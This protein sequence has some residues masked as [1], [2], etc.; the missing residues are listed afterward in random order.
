MKLPQL[1]QRLLFSKKAQTAEQD[2]EKELRSQ[3]A[4]LERQGVAFNESLG[5]L[6]AAL[7][8]SNGAELTEQQRAQDLAQLRLQTQTSPQAIAVE[9]GAQ[10]SAE[11]WQHY[12]LQTH[13]LRTLY[14]QIL[15]EKQRFLHHWHELLRNQIA[16]LPQA[17]QRIVLTLLENT[18]EGVLTLGIEQMEAQWQ[19]ELEQMK[20]QTLLPIPDLNAEHADSDTAHP[21]TASSDNLPQLH[22]PQSSA[23]LLEALQAQCE[24][25][26][27]DEN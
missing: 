24:L 18:F 13:T 4:E 1:A 12:V 7:S 16:Q 8:I 23:S 21:T 10:L 19:E 5:L 11:S 22:L 17:R 6:R 27:L 26:S 14:Q 15:K 3:I 9:F 20:E 2:L 25:E